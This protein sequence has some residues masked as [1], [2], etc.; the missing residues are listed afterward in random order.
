MGRTVINERFVVRER[1][2]AKFCKFPPHIFAGATDYHV[3]IGPV[4]FHF[5]GR[6]RGGRASN[7]VIYAGRVSIVIPRRFSRP[8][9][10]ADWREQ[11]E[12]TWAP[13]ITIRDAEVR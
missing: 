2:A 13:Y 8:P 10:Y 6:S 9:T 3:R 4:S 5:S 1:G 11:N 12:R 7:T